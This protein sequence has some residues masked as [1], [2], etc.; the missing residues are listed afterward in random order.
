MKSLPMESVVVSVGYSTRYMTNNIFYPFHQSTD[1]WYLCGFNEPDAAMI[2]KKDASTRGYKQIMFVSPKNPKV[3]LWEGPCT[4][5]DGVKELFGA[6]EGYENSRFP[7]YLQSCFTAPHL[8]MDS[9]VLTPSL[10]S[11]SGSKMAIDVGL[12]KK[13]VKPLSKYVQELRLIKSDGEIELMKQSGYISSKAFIEAMKW[14]QPG[15]LEDQLWAKMEYECRMHGSSVLAYVPVVA[16]GPN[17]LSLHYVRNDMVLKDGDLVLVDCGG[18]YNGYASDI[19]RTWPVNGKFTEPQRQ[20]YQAVLNVNKMC[21]KLCTEEADV[22]LHAIHAASVDA[23]KNELGAIGFEA[24]RQ[25]IETIL[26]PHHV[27][28]YLGLDVHDV[29]SI[30]RSRKLKSNTVITIEPG[31]YVPYNDKFPAQFQG[32]GIRIED[33]VVIGRE[34]PYVLTAT[35]P[36][37]IVDIEFCCA[38]QKA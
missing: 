20:L 5:I 19:T 28:H 15:Y 24:S 12:R 38:N 33:N 7:S 36:K 1:F 31:L 14:T 6:D 2:L 3:E 26:Y 9:P 18:E 23:M 22:S 8:F 25:D 16:G 35:A 34:T 27:G 13:A 4:G 37:E 30:D 21:I 11:Q 17:A 29:H 32:I 10:M